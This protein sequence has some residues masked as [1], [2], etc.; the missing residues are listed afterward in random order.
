[1]VIAFSVASALVIAA[2]W[3]WIDQFF[4]AVFGFWGDVL[5]I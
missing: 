1:M 3:N 2:P 4:E 5:S